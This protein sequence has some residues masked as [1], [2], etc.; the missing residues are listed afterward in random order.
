MLREGEVIAI[1]QEPRYTDTSVP[2]GDKAQYAVRAIYDKGVSAAAEATVQLSG[3]SGIGGDGIA[4]AVEG[5]DIVVT[6]AAGQAVTLAAADGKI[7]SCIASAADSERISVAEQGI[8][9]LRVG[10]FVRKVAVR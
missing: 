1:V 10:T 4:V 2:E 7:V 8:Y 6:G 5:R 9:I 3:I